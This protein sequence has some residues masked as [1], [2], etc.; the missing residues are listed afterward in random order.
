MLGMIAMVS[1][2]VVVNIAML[3]YMKLRIKRNVKK[4]SKK[5]NNLYTQN[6][7][8]DRAILLN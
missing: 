5:I 4:N 6:I 3:L 8:N 1:M 2:L 7:C